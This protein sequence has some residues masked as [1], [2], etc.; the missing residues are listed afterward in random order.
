[1]TDLR[2]VSFGEAFGI[3]AKIG[4]LSFGGPAGQIALMHRIL[5]DEKKWLSE[6]QFLHALNFCML[7]PGPEA[8]QLATYSGWLLHGLKGGLA[9]GLMFI[10]PGVAVMLGLSML[11]AAYADLG[12]VEA[13][14][15]GIKAAVFAIVI[16]ALIRISKRVMKSG[17]L[18]AVAAAAF[19]AI[20]FFDVPF[21]LVVAAAA[22]FGLAA[23]RRAPWIFGDTLKAPEEEERRVNGG[24]HT[25]ASPR[26][27]FVTALV[28]L[29]LWLGPVAALILFFGMGHVFAQEAVFFSKMAVITFGG[30]YAV[31]AYVAQEAV[32]NYGWLNP[33]EMLDGLGL[34]ETTPGPLILVLQFVGYLAAHRAETGIN[35]ALAGAIGALV[36]VWVTF[37]PCFLWIFL[38]APYVERLRKVATLNA[39]FTAITAAVVGVILNLAIWFGLHVL[40]G[41]VEE[42]RTGIL[43]LWIPDTATLDP[44]A[45]ALSVAALVAVLRFHAGMLPA[46]GMAAAAGVAISFL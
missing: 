16:E 26:R 23:A 39:A 31:L 17:A 1:M 18:Y 15:F 41:E 28:G 32:Q 21:P 12:L 34:A 7:L 43:R 11:Y 13:V 42:V 30:A 14:F 36:T 25:R 6:P 33:G 44:W 10:L 20:F 38:G 37:A 29:A 27:T 45:L 46:L 3:W 22:L 5:V 24:D 2:T 8:Q 40:F 4:F 35:P 9:A 19:A